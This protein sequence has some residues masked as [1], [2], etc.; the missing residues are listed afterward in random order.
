MYGQSPYVVNANLDY[1]N[2]ETGW[3]GN[4]VFNVFGARLAYFTTALPF[5]FEQP[6]PELNLSIKKQLNDRWSVRARANNLLNP[7][8]EET[9]DFKGEEFIFDQ[10]TMGRDFSISFTY[11]V[12]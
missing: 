1:N 4:A 12:E 3:S 5:V 9:I 11:L 8:Y 7:K 10:Y 6:R 2:F